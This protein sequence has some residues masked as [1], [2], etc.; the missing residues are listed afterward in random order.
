M[1]EKADTDKYFEATSNP[2]AV[3]MMDEAAKHGYTLLHD[4]AWEI[5]DAF[6][7]AYKSAQP[8]AL[9]DA[10]ARGGEKDEIGKKYWI[11]GTAVFHRVPDGES[12]GYDSPYMICKC[13][14]VQQA[15]AIRKEIIQSSQRGVTGEVVEKMAKAI[16]AVMKGID[17]NHRKGD[18]LLEGAKD[19]GFYQ[20][21]MLA[22]QKY[23]VPWKEAAAMAQAVQEYRDIISG[24][25]GQK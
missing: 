21:Q 22:S 5:A 15:H 9:P 8:P 4:E 3:V 17:W 24:K 14:T 6:I 23:E 7:K 12:R 20:K 11:M 25:E 13:D 16:E 2:M 19:G 10:P 1:T 18:I